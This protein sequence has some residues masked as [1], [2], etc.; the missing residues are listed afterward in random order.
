MALFW[1]VDAVMLL[2]FG[3]GYL[4]A[5]VH[6]TTAWWLQPF[7]I[8]LPYASL[9]VALMTMAVLGLR[10]RRARWGHLVVVMLVAIRFGP[11]WLS[12]AAA[13]QAEAFS[14]I[15]FNTRN[16]AN[17]AAAGERLAQVVQQQQPSLMALQETWVRQGERVTYSPF[18]EP[19]SS[20]GYG[21]PPTAPGEQPRTITLPV[22]AKGNQI[23][24]EQRQLRFWPDHQQRFEL[25]RGVVQ[26]DDKA[27]VV[28]NVHLR[29]HGEE[30]PWQ[31][32]Q[33]AW[34]SPAFWRP[35]LRRIKQDYALRAR[36]A[37]VIKALLEE[38]AQPVMLVGDFNSPP[39]DWVYRHLAQGMADAFVEA[40]QGWGGTYHSRLPF[41]RIDHILLSPELKA[42]RAEVLAP[43]FSD[44]L[45][46]VV[47]VV[48][49]D[50]EDSAKTDER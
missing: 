4:A 18:V 11:G 29:S 34:L 19:L 49:A 45:P 35:Y 8:V 40:G 25:G 26:F 42:V 39:H 38:E 50:A 14:V 48:W 6:P 1:L 44:H 46:Q 15:V 33:P 5:Y 36:Q 30:K 17:D 20:I 16:G 9:G 12:S 10:R 37:E 23:T 43:L 13:T 3:C 21:V 31:A 28:Y 24:F 41:V 7:A 32:D 2:V 22:L 27:F 47:E